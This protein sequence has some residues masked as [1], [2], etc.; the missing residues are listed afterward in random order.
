MD[1]PPRGQGPD[2]KLIRTRGRPYLKFF[3]FLSLS[4]LF[5]FSLFLS[6]FHREK[7]P[8]LTYIDE[9]KVVED[10]RDQQPTSFQRRN[11]KKNIPVFQVQEDDY[12]NR[13]RTR[14]ERRRKLREKREERE[15]RKRNW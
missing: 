13:K 10:F 8:K 12:D 9:C 5:S 6:L 7:F 3:S 11:N 2:P 15:E 4:F 14:D 1:L